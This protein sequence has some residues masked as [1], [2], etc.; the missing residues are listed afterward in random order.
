M[1]SPATLRVSVDAAAKFDL[2]E[3]E[4]YTTW[5]PNSVYFTQPPGRE[6]Y[7]LLG[8]L[9]TQLPPGSTVADVGTYLGFSALALSAASNLAAVESYDIVDCM[10]EP[11]A[12]GQATAHDRSNIRLHVSP[13][14]CF[15]VEAMDAIC[16]CPLIVLDVD[17]HD[18]VQER[19][20]MAELE[21]RAYRGA[22]VCDDIHLNAE[23]SAFWYDVRQPKRD[24]THAGHWSGTG[25]V[26]FGD[27]FSVFTE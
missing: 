11:R 24:I 25:I 13:G 26:V 20:F 18:G 8:Q 12:Q 1:S 17:P 15:D 6:H 22:V 23:M 4:R 2:S 3:V 19:R 9:A 5:N 10:A 27:A 7:R 16:A 21:R 14:G